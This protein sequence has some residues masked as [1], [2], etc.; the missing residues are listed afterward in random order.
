MKSW[1][2]GA[3]SALF[4]ASNAIAA[5]RCG[6]LRPDSS[7][8]RERIDAQLS[9]RQ[10]ADSSPKRIRLAKVAETQLSV[11]DILVGFDYSA[12]RWLASDKPEQ[13][14]ESYAQV[15]VDHMNDSLRASDI[16]EFSFRLA[17]VVRLQEDLS[18][19]IVAPYYFHNAIG[20]FV[21]AMGDVVASGACR[22]L[23]DRREEVGADIV[24]ILIDSATNPLSAGNVVMAG[25]GFSLEDDRDATGNLAPDRY[26]YSLHPELIPSFGDWAYNCC[27]IRHVDESNAQVMLHEIGHNM[28]CGHA[29]TVNPSAIEPGPQLYQ[30]SAAS[31]FRGVDNVAYYTIMGYNFDG[32]GNSYEPAPVFSSPLLTYAGVATGDESH[33]NRKTLL[34]TFRFAA[35]YRVSKSAPTPEPSPSPS[36]DDPDSHAVFTAK[37]VVNG[38][39]WDG[40]SV[41]GLVQITVAKTDKKN[42]SRVS[43]VVTGLDGKKLIGKAVKCHVRGTAT[44]AKVDVAIMVKGYTEPLRAI[45]ASDGTLSEASIGGLTIGMTNLEPLNSTSPTFKLLSFPSEIN[46]QT[47]LSD[48][49]PYQE[50]FEVSGTKWTFKK[51]ASVKFK[52]NRVTHENELVVD[53]GR[54]GSKNNKS[55]LKLTYAPKTGLFKGTFTAY[56]MTSTQKLKK[57]KF[58]VIGLVVGGEGMGIA[59]LKKSA[60]ELP[61]I[62][63]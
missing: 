42:H 12:V 3:S 47:V 10:T 4:L 37:T 55:G 59:V 49:L 38:A 33:D 24:S 7:A 39:L 60:I 20:R 21:N 9:V 41:I 53:T 50:K 63:R 44:T 61:V 26:R 1:V 17:G 46:H 43:A 32:Y 27:S 29:D 62:I 23:T 35:Q 8:L 15:C 58:S 56:A 54:D 36:P 6:Q 52:K 22:A 13:T 45:V 40:D 19:D 2:L 48:L 5:G 30:Y 16:T 18:G 14:P 57:Y 51:A 31:H 25:A 28:G 11:I 34:K